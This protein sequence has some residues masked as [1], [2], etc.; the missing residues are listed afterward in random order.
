[1]ALTFL[2]F[3]MFNSEV[4]EDEEVALNIRFLYY[5]KLEIIST[6]SRLTMSDNLRKSALSK[7]VNF[8]HA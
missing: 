7:L 2:N 3:V 4:L 6:K 5:P 8:F 1:M